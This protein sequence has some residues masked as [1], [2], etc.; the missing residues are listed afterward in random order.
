MK[1]CCRCGSTENGFYKQSQKPDGL[2]PEC[3]VC[4]TKTNKAWQDANRDEYLRCHR[5]AQLRWNQS[6]PEEA[7]ARCKANWPNIQAKR[8]AVIDAAKAAGCI[9]CPENRL[10]CLV[11][12]HLGDKDTEV[13]KLRTAK[14]VLTELGKC[15]VMCSNCHLLHHV[16]GVTLPDGVKP[17]DV[18]PLRVLAADARFKD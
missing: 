4:T 9:I 11:F 3:K 13:S 16:D 5:N 17:I 12:H 18:E 1:A 14:A 15:V 10:A 2:R 6:H 8:K 7:K